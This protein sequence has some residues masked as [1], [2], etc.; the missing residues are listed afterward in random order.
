M[1]GSVNWAKVARWQVLLFAVLAPV[2]AVLA[3]V[4]VVMA[5]TDRQWSQAIGWGILLVVMAPAAV[6]RV[7]LAPR[8]LRRIKE[9]QA[10]GGSDSTPDPDHS[11]G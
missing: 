5:G 4:L 10:P 6:L 8:Q 1:A 7:L 11:L 2:V 3:L 9:A